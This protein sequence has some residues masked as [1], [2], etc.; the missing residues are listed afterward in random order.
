MFAGM[1]DNGAGSPGSASGP[2]EIVSQGRIQFNEDGEPVSFEETRWRRDE[3]AGGGG[4]KLSPLTPFKDGGPEE[5]AAAVGAAGD[6]GAVANGASSPPALATTEGFAHDLVGSLDT[7]EKH[8]PRDWLGFMVTVQEQ[9]QHATEEAYRQ[10]NAPVLEA[11]RVAWM[12]WLDRRADSLD[13]LRTPRP[14]A[15]AAPDDSPVLLER[16]G[17]RHSEEVR[18]LV[19]GGVPH[20]L[21]A[22]IWPLLCGSREAARREAAEQEPLGWGGVQA[23]IA[24]VGGAYDALHELGEDTA[25]QI[26]KDVPRTL[27]RNDAFKRVRAPR[28]AAAAAAACCCLLLLAAACCFCCRC[29]NGVGAVR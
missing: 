1:E 6:D 10:R 11:A 28:A 15:A 21:R 8:R 29:N 9:E 2:R 3:A 24:E 14:D 23:R 22:R 16:H 25:Q 18:Q 12:D 27:S 13:D 20:E 4:T 17:W 5:P 7:F 26:A 19:R